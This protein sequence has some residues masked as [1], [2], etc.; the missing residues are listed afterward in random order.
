MPRPLKKLP[1][2]PHIPESAVIVVDQLF[3]RLDA[4]FERAPEDFKIELIKIE[5]EFPLSSRC[6]KFLDFVP[7]TEEK[8][9]FQRRGSSG[10]LMAEL[11]DSFNYFICRYFEFFRND[12]KVQFV[13]T[14]RGWMIFKIDSEKV[15][16]GTVFLEDLY[17]KQVF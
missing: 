1:D 5:E 17:A 7:F 10:E 6:I 8:H 11:T 14:S 12:N 2:I 13:A 15:V 16:E 3:N 9:T 4:I